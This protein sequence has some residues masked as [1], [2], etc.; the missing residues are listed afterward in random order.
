MSSFSGTTPVEKV[1]LWD[2]VESIFEQIHGRCGYVGLISFE[3]PP[4]VHL[5]LLAYHHPS[6]DQDIACYPNET[7]KH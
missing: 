2:K 4:L 3:I 5:Y 1:Q 6:C 7:A